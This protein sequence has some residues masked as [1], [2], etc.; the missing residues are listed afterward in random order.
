MQPYLDLL[1][2]ILDDPMPDIGQPMHFRLRP[3]FNKPLQTIRPKAPILHPPDQTTRP[4][5]EKWQHMLNRRET[6]PS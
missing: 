2:R 1:R 6:A 3:G 4:I 5:C